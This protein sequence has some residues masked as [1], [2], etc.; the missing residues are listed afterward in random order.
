MKRRLFLS[1]LAFASNLTA[2]R[3]WSP[4]EIQR[5]ERTYKGEYLPQPETVS[6]G[7]RRFNY[8]KRKRWVCAFVARYQV[9]DSLSPD[10]GGIIEAE[11]LPT[12]IETDNT[13]EAIWVWSRHHQI[14]GSEYY[15]ENIRRAWIYVLRNPAYR[16]HGG[17]PA[18]IW[19]AV[20]N[21]GL[22]LMAE[23][24]Y[25]QA[26]QDSS[27]LFYADS[28][29]DF[30]LRHPLNPNNILENFVTAQASGMA[31]DYALERN[32]QELLDT[33]LARGIRVKNWIEE[34]ARSRLAY[35]SWAMAGGTAFW[36]ICH[37]F[38]QADTVAGKAWIETYADSLPGFYPS[39]TWNCSHNIWLAN[40]YRAAGEIG[41]NEEHWAIHQYLTDTLLM[42]DT[43]LDGGIP[44]TWTDPET[45]DQTWVSTYLDF[46]GLDA[47]CDTFY[48]CDVCLYDFTSPVRGRL[49]IETIGDS[50]RFRM[51]NCGAWSVTGWIHYGIVGGLMQQ[52]LLEDIPPDAE[53][54][55]SYLPIGCRRGVNRFIGI[56]SFSGDQNPKNDT[57]FVD[58]KVYGRFPLFGLLLDSISSTPIYAW[59]KAYLGN[60]TTVW[61]SCLTN[62]SGEFSLNLIDSTFRVSIEPELP[63]YRRHWT[64]N[65][66]GDTTIVLRTSPAQVMIV[67]NDTLENYTSYYTTSL[68]SLNVTWCLWKKPSQGLVPYNLFDRLQNR[69]VIWF[70][71][72]T[73]TQTI[74]VADQESLANFI[75]RDGNLLLTGQNIAEELAGTHFLEGIIGCRFDS[76]GWRGFLAFGNRSDS[77]GRNITGTSTAGGNGAN[78]QIS[79]DIV[80][81]LLNSNLFLVYDTITNLGAGISREIQSAGKVILLGFG[82]EAVNRPVSKPEYYTRVQLMELMLDWLFSPT[83]I[84]ETTLREKSTPRLTIIP[85][86]FKKHLLVKTDSPT[87][88]GLFDIT[89]RQIA[90]FH[91]GSGT[92]V[93]HLPSLPSGVYFA[94]TDDS[95][96]ISLVK[97]R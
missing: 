90:S 13:Q 95:H 66:T 38:C 49:Y 21:C 62:R 65:L 50:A 39:G 8:L 74:P 27:Y 76:S 30:Y 84:T 92:A 80:S 25:R 34:N 78:N 3:I 2:T 47:L 43:D 6:L 70:T 26:Y 22:G 59:V 10:F 97:I 67:N 41:H 93:W 64:I 96:P 61:D 24:K 60:D 44:A 77:L 18:I 46:M 89:G 4:E 7:P 85:A 42:R 68:D 69:T 11:H 87:L 17:N 40:A 16:E 71:G 82:F 36:G 20:W 63:Y 53:S 28:C 15:Q 58:I 31:Y 72:N 33:A 51:E 48:S 9:S 57:T 94:R 45:Q 29:R 1:I 52:R 35:Q 37:T 88:I 54:T 12:I 86:I 23:A 56:A 81:P 55:I 19:Y 75:L 14:T 79:R 5:H 91:A 73:Q 32:D 83:G